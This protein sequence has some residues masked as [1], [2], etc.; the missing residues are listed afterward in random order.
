MEANF[1]DFLLGEYCNTSPQHDLEPVRQ[2]VEYCK[3]YTQTNPPAGTATV[4]YG[5]A[6]RMTHGEVL[7]FSMKDQ[8]PEN[9]V[10]GIFV[11][12]PGTYPMGV[13]PSVSVDIT[14]ANK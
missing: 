13:E 7:G 6:V 8:K 9:P 11:T 12:N 3:K 4:G 5:L 10:R 2:F 1:F 14:D